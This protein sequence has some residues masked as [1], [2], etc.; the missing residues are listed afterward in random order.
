MAMCGLFHGSRSRDMDAA[1]HGGSIIDAQIMRRWPAPWLP[2]L[3]VDASRRSPPPTSRWWA[4]GH[5][6][7]TMTALI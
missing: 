1:R 5:D 3:A 4:A 6:R 7:D 2:E